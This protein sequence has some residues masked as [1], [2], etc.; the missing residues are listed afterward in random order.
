VNAYQNG[1]EYVEEIK[2]PNGRFYQKK[3]VSQGPGF[4][5]VTIMSSGG[6]N[7]QGGSLFD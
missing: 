3:V 6:F 1:N 4:Q 2:D 7:I 5:S